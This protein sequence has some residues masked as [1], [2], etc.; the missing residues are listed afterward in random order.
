MTLV[1]VIMG[2]WLVV[3]AGV[4]LILCRAMHDAE[5]RDGGPSRVRVA[6]PAVRLGGDSE[7]TR[8]RVLVEP[9]PDDLA[10]WYGWRGRPPGRAPAGPPGR[11]GAGDAG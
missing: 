3:A 1:L 11:P 10:T 9:D 6:G 2:V 5:L 4:S 7:R 8:S